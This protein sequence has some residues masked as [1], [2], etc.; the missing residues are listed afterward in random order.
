MRSRISFVIALVLLLACAPA[1][2]QLFSDWQ[3]PVNVGT[4]VNSYPED[5]QPFI[6]KDGLS[7]YFSRIEGGNKLYVAKRAS[8]SEAWGTPERLPDVINLP[9]AGQAFVTVDGHF[10]LFSSGRP[11]GSGGADLWLS[12][13]KDKNVESGPNGWG[14]PVNLGSAVNSSAAEQSPCLVEDELTGTTKLYFSSDRFGTHD[15]FSATLQS[16]GTFSTS[17]PIEELN[18]PYVD[19]HPT[20]SRD[21]LEVYFS[22]NRPGSMVNDNGIPSYDIW[23]ASRASASVAWSAP[24]PV[25]AINSRYHDGRP[26]LAFDGSSLYFFSAFRTEDCAQRGECNVGIYFDIWMAQREK[27]VGPE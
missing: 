19:Q 24:Q 15:L 18:G 3:P 4:P 8:V 2:A 27:L 26:S 6:S 21:G 13:R 1:W 11:G 16:D 25:T 20:V 10:L 14:T 23:V 22:S 9:N 5:Y 7:L 12:R 17:Q